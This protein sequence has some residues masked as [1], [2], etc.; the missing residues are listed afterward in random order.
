[1]PRGVK[2]SGPYSKYKSTG[3]GGKKT[4]TKTASTK[5]T[6][7]KPGRKPKQPV[8]A[9]P[10]GI[11]NQFSRFEEMRAVRDNICA[12]NLILS[13]AD[14]HAT[15]AVRDALGLQVSILTSLT[16]EAFSTHIPKA[17]P[18]V[19]AGV[20]TS[21]TAQVETTEDTTTE[22]A[23]STPPLPP[24]ANGVTAPPLPPQG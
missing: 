21:P 9:Q 7:A 18:V 24:P 8:L 5:K 10:T 11:A 13:S 16:R 19:S 12:L 22:E 15:D 2:G 14:R 1:M 23:S 6:A 17:E 4:T 3:R 20:G